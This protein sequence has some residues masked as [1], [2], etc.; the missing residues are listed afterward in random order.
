MYR[1]PAIC[2][3]FGRLILWIVDKIGVLLILTAKMPVT[4]GLHALAPGT[5][6]TSGVSDIA[7]G[8]LFRRS[9]QP[10]AFR[11]PEPAQKLFCRHPLLSGSLDFEDTYITTAHRYL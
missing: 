8:A 11:N 6:M 9:F 5:R 3:G 1:N 4:S 7:P 2:Q 10:I